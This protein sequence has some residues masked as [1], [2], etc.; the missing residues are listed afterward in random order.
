MWL[1]SIRACAVAPLGRPLAGGGTSG[2]A[3][4]VSVWSILVSSPA[5]AAAEAAEPAEAAPATRRSTGAGNTAHLGHD[6]ALPRGEAGED[7]GVVQIADAGLH[8]HAHDLIVG[9][10]GD[11]IAAEGGRLVGRGGHDRDVLGSCGDDG[12]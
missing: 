9:I 7:L 8:G 2:H 5:T 12:Q 11:D 1:I 4:T 10:Q 6:D 3:N